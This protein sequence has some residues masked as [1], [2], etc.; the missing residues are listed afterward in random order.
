MQSLGRRVR[1]AIFGDLT[2]A[3]WYGGPEG[4]SLLDGRTF[5]SLISEQHAHSNDRRSTMRHSEPIT[6]QQA[7]RA[8]ERSTVDDETFQSLT[9]ER[10][11]HSNDRRSTMSMDLPFLPWQYAGEH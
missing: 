2:A 8:L 6:H 3:Y 1:G 9:S 11:A 5:Q 4:H 7:A 10:H